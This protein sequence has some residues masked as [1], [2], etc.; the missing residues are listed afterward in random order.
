MAVNG[1]RSMAV[2]GVRSM[3]VNGGQW[4][5]VGFGRILMRARN[6]GGDGS[7]VSDVHQ[8]LAG[9]IFSEATV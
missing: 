8:V 9:A 4:R 7:G 1:V 5:T 3:A 2:N 6:E